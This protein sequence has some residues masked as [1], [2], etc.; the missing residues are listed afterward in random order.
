MFL[1]L[2]APLPLPMGY[3]W[4]PPQRARIGWV[5]N[6]LQCSLDV[7]ALSPGHGRVGKAVPSIATSGDVNPLPPQVLKR[8][9]HHS[10][11]IIRK[12]R[13]VLEGED[14]CPLA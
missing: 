10:D 8:L 2:A 6:L 13:S 9:G 1:L 14:I 7:N 4:P 12:G 11:S 3:I 5:L